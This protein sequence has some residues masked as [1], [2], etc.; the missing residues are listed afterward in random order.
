MATDHE[1]MSRMAAALLAR[2]ARRRPGLLMGL[3]TGATPAGAYE[4]M[5]RAGAA[6]SSLL[7]GVRVLKLDEWLGLP[8]DHPATSETYLREKV[9]GPW[10]VP[11]SRYRGFKSR[12][13][14]PKA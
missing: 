4:R 9:L 1:G 12:P 3:A 14:D 5:A 2:E 13:R 7:A 6:D 8:V 10:G 11:R